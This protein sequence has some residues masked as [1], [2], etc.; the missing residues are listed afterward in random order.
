MFFLVRYR[1]GEGAI[2]IYPNSTKFFGTRTQYSVIRYDASL[3]VTRRSMCRRIIDAEHVSRCYNVCT[4]QSREHRD[5]EAHLSPHS[6]DKEG[7][8]CEIF[9]SSCVQKVLPVEALILDSVYEKLAHKKDTMEAQIGPQRARRWCYVR[10]SFA[11]FLFAAVA[12]RR[13][14]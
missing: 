11:L 9:I 7:S 13:P 1:E 5:K 8:K 4:P 10:F 6:A 12:V 2:F 3:S 14:L